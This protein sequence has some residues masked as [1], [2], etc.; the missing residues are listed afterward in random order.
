MVTSQQASGNSKL[1]R[2]F[3]KPEVLTG[4]AQRSPAVR[5]LQS[6]NEKVFPSHRLAIT[7]MAGH[8]CP[9]KN[10]SSTEKTSGT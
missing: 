8:F 1:K 10:F 2:L 5:E 3:Y 9:A 7:R 4:C 6:A